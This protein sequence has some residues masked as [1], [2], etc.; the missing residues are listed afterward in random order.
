MKKQPADH[1][2]TQASS[3]AKSEMNQD[4]AKWADLAGCWLEKRFA[5]E[6]PEKTAFEE[7]LKKGQI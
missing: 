6:L 3:G 4:A 5:L 7:T 1:L 2:A